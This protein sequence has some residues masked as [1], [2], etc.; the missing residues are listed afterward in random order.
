MKEPS[1]QSWQI[2]LMVTND[3]GRK[4]RGQKIKIHYRDANI[5]I[6]ETDRGLRHHTFRETFSN[7]QNRNS[8]QSLESSA[9]LLNCKNQ[10]ML[11]GKW[12]S[13]LLNLLFNYQQNTVTLSSY[14]VGNKLMPVKWGDTKTSHRIPGW[15]QIKD[16]AFAIDR[17]L[18]WWFIFSRSVMSQMVHWQTSYRH[19]HSG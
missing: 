16:V 19:I 2:K 14:Q 8:P 1:I 4:I 15:R 9:S 3:I 5:F 6:L 12:L 11:F 7:L 17:I 10:C 13:Q 18:R